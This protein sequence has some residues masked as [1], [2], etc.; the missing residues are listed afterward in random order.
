[1]AA[2]RLPT[3]IE[4]Q[5]ARLVDAA[6][7]GDEWL[8]EVKFDGYR[9]LIWKGS[10]GVRIR[11]RG[12]QDWTDKLP[13]TVR[14]AQQ[15]PCASAVLDGEL[16]TLDAAGVSSF[17]KL[18]QR[19]GSDERALRVMVFDLLW[20]EGTD[21]RPLPQ[22][23]R[24]ARLAALM[25]RAKAP[26]QL[27]AYTVGDG[28]RAAREACAHGLEGIICKAA[29]AP[30]AGGR[31]GNWLKVKCTASDEFAILAYTSGQGAREA[32]G[33]L[34][35]GTPAGA[36]RWRYMGRVGTGFNDRTIEDLLKRLERSAGPP[37]LVNPPSRAQ[38]RY[39]TPHWVR[40]R[41]VVEVEFR[42][43]TEEGLLRQAS[44]KGV[45]ADRSVDSL[46]PARRDHARVGAPKRRGR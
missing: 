11:S 46:K 38:L 7:E 21:L 8:H 32:L 16:V 44:L 41:F 34:V 30:Y 6:P 33:S 25:A 37:S 5:L 40:P 22:R 10:E 2:A 19:F 31:S 36:G 1:A 3:A 9:V 17:G 29:D 24:S 15:L 43:Y 42:G 28:P 13:E 4:L 27:T 35:L 12:E 14:A 39:A 26:L 45:R 20:L 18:Q 23:E